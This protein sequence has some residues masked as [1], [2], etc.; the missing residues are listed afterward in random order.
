MAEK[1]ADQEASFLEKL[2]SSSQSVSVKLPKINLPHFSGDYKDWPCFRDLFTGSVDNNKQLTTTQK[3]QHLKS[4]LRDDAA[5]LVKH[6]P[7]S[8]I[9]LMPGNGWKKDTIERI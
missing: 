7:V 2:N 9:T 6:I 5:N 8:P 4:L 3:F 1:L